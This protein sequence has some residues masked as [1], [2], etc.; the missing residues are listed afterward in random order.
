MGGGCS[1]EALVFGHL[2]FRFRGLVAG[3]EKSEEVA[4][5]N[6]VMKVAIVDR[7]MEGRRGKRKR[8]DQECVAVCIFPG[9]YIHK[10]PLITC[11]TKGLGPVY[12][13]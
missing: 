9:I 10:C 5:G 7:D 6:G 12:V 2:P 1:C 8:T 3:S 11:G 4:H 13:S